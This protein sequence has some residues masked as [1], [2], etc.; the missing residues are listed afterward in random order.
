[1][2]VDEIAAS[3]RRNGFDS[4]KP[5]RV[6]RNAFNN[7]GRR[8]VVDGHTRLAAAKRAKL[9]DV[10]IDE[11]D[12][13]SVA[14]ALKDAIREQRQR[15]NLS[16]DQVAVF[17]VRSLRELRQVGGRRP[18]ATQL[19]TLLG[20]SKSTIDR[21]NRILDDG[22]EE[23]IQGVLDGLSLL[24]AYEQLRETQR[25][26]PSPLEE[27]VTSKPRLP[28]ER[29]PAVTAMNELTVTLE[30]VRHRLEDHPAPRAFRQL[31]VAI[32]AMAT[33]MSA[34]QVRQ[35]FELAFLLVVAAQ[36]RDL[37]DLLGDDSPEDAT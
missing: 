10:F 22:G 4:T 24:D 28:V 9:A 30:E 26:S 35:D 33:E 6:W 1:M 5:I 23:L 27:G 36:G 14:E 15:R 37:A 18:P 11:R 7:E 13:V 19:A 17:A 32:E 21:A 20:T 31:A 16:R 12:Y 2:L 3:M 8:V 29:R 34:E 25:Q